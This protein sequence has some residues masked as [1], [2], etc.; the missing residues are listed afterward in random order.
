[1]TRIELVEGEDE[2]SYYNMIMKMQWSYA[3]VILQAECGITES[4]H[5]K[6]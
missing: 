4:L 5:E 6:L 2:V 3:V 1:M